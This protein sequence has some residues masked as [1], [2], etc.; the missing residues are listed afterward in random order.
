MLIESSVHPKDFVN[1]LTDQ[2]KRYRQCCNNDA[3]FV[4]VDLSGQ[5]NSLTDPAGNELYCGDRE[6]R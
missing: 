6:V 5:G 4:C 2:L 3:V 1:P